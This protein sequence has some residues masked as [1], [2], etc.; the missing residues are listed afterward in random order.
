MIFRVILPELI[1]FT[2]PLILVTV[3]L[4]FQRVNE[5]SPGILY[6]KGFEVAF[7]TLNLV[8]GF[9]EI[10]IWIFSILTILGLYALFRKNRHNGVLLSV[11]LIV[12]LIL[13][14]FLS[15][16]IPFGQR[17]LLYLIPLFFVAIAGSYLLIPKSLHPEK[18]AAICIIALILF[19]VPNIMLYYTTPTKND[20][21]GASDLVY[22]L[23]KNGDLV[24][25]TPSI[26]EF[27]YYY[28]NK[29]DN[30]LLYSARNSKDLIEITES[31]AGHNIYYVVSGALGIEN[32]EGD[33]YQWLFSNCHPVWPSDRPYIFQYAR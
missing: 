16:Y 22:D 10:L 4:F 8:S 18:I 14:L 23:T 21:R 20:W 26:I 17:Y 30:T 7:S 32:P 28:D 13:S 19:N 5:G 9:N 11:L 27:S 29:S 2:L 12:P 1:I 25:A 6:L 31:S 33:G 3:S 15:Y 24:V